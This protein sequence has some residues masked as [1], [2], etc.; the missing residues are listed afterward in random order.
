MKGKNGLWVFISLA[1]ALCVTSCEVVEVAPAAETSESSFT[2]SVNEVP[3]EPSQ[4]EA[5]IT[6]DLQESSVN[7]DNYDNF[8]ALLT[9]LVYAYENPGEDRSGIIDEEIQ[10]I[11]DID[12]ADGDIAQAVADIWEDCFTAPDDE[13]LMA[14]T[15]DASLSDSGIP[16]SPSHAIVILGFEL[17]NG[18]M[19]DELIGRLQAAAVL[20]EAF[21][22]TYIV[23][24][25]GATGENN[26][27]GNTEAGLMRDYLI[28]ECE[29]T[30]S[31]IFA[32][33]EAMTTADNAV[34][35]YRILLENDIHSITIVTSSYHM[36]W[37][38]A[39]YRTVGELYFDQTGI[40]VTSIG[41]FCFD[42]EPSSDILR[43]GDR[44]AARQIGQIIGIP[45]DFLQ[46]LPSLY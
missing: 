34:N 36:R 38:Q 29:I 3:S 24:S 23:C 1:V 30:P 46:S 45:E 22:E 28:E 14:G 17:K 11:R 2:E 27:S 5:P 43:R 25:G 40:E 6:F 35:T 31:R 37:G 19:Q 4:T 44:F 41:N 8:T 26:T 18:Q 39:V 42:T 16:D 9:E 20:A 33:E 15:D 7:E 10:A 12:P 13:L 32:D 21:P